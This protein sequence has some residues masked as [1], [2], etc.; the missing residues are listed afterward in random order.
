MGNGLDKTD[1]TLQPMSDSP[2][3]YFSNLETK[4][5]AYEVW[6]RIEEYYNEMRR[7]GRLALYRNSY[8]NFYMGWIYRASIYRSGEEGELTRSFWNHERNLLRHLKVQTTQNKIAYKAQVLNSNSKSANAVEFA[9]GLADRYSQAVEYDLDGK[10]KQS[11]EDTLV[12]GESAI[13]AL[14]SKHK[15][16]PM[17]QDPETG[18]ILNDGDMDYFNVTPMDHII[19]CAHQSRDLL[20]WRCIR[21]WVNKYDLAAMYPELAGIVKLFNDSESSY[22]TKLVSLIHHDRETIPIFYFFHDKTPAVPQGRMLVMADPTCIFEDGPL[23]HGDNQRGYDHIPVYDNIVEVMQGS[24]Y[25]YSVAFDLIPFQQTLNELVSAVT[26]NNINFAIQCVM[27]MKGANIQFQQLAT[28]MSFIEYDPKVGDK[29]KPEPLNLLSSKPE[30]YQFIDM[31]IKNMETIAGVNSMVRGNPEGD[32]T[33][34]QYAALV[35]VQSVLFNSGLQKGYARL[36]ENVMTGTIKTIKKNMIGK[37]IA[38]IVGE[39]SDPYL[40]EFT[41]SDLQDIESITVQLVNPMIQTPAG[42]MAMADSLMKT[43]LIKDAQQYIGVYTDGDL[44]QLYK[45]QE[46]QLKLVKQE[47]EMLLKGQCP[48]V[49]VTDN[50]VMHILEHTVIFDNIEARMNP[51]LPSFVSAMQHVQLHLN[52]LLGGTDPR[53]GNLEGPINPVLAGIIGDPTL[54]LGTPSQM[55]LPPMAPGSQPP[56]GPPQGGPPQAPPQPQSP[57]GQPSQPAQKLPPTGAPGPQLGLLQ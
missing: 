17:A 56:A 4:Q 46:T 35:T 43:G 18:Q 10:G 50:H 48:E 15:G 54:P 1:L 12:W 53:N 33:S 37:K 8:T 20:Q 14:W 24:P 28:G 11:V 44:P 52:K 5:C 7:T 49:A 26:S 27:A 55:Q 51:S 3:E 42:K 22:A 30:T 34:G 21:R 6:S 47:N 23:D 32:I 31:I 29:G 57:P 19:N 40:K 2:E 36:M 38:R 41:S 16:E 39:T 25:G 45:R 9:N 13:V